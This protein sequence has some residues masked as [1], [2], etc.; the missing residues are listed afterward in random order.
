MSATTADFRHL[1]DAEVVA[2]ERFVHLLEAEQKL[3]SD[4]AVD[5]LPDLL[6]EKNGLAAQ[7]TGLAD[8]RNRALV[9][10]G[11]TA[12]RAGIARWFSLHPGESAAHAVW[13]RLLPLASQARELNRVNGE[14]I[15]LR[16]QHNT[17]ALEA[18]LGSSGALGLYG[19]DGQNAPASGQRI[20]DRA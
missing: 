13:S 8:L 16:L 17:L 20:S 15:Q 4:G 12:D 9:A 14:L 18:L 2:V 6:R 5:E 1:I 3:L 19:P 7:L 11:L 10:H